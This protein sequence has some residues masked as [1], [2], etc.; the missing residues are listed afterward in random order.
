[1]NI[2]HARPRFEILLLLKPPE[3][4]LAQF[5]RASAGGKAL[6]GLPEMEVGRSPKNVFDG[7]SGA[8]NDLSIPLPVG[9]PT[10]LTASTGG[11]GG[12]GGSVSPEDSASPTLMPTLTPAR[13]R[14]PGE[15]DDYST[16]RRGSTTSAS[17]LPGEVGNWMEGESIGGGGEI[18]MGPE[19]AA[20]A[21]AEEAEL[22]ALQIDKND[23]KLVFGRPFARGKSS[24]VYQVTHEGR[25]RAAKVRWNTNFNIKL[26]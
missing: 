4:R 17:P 18:I 9:N 6:H 16:S 19:A 13:L 24:E 11:G 21:F 12:V 10:P 20:Q 1:M 7:N 14:H 3:M 8:G 2:P 22:E 26:E 15:V 25:N 23:L 5:V